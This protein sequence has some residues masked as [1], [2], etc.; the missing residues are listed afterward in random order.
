MAK[1]VFKSTSI[2]RNRKVVD[3][4]NYW[5]TL[6]GFAPKMSKAG[7]SINFNPIMELTSLEDG[8]PAPTKD[9]GKAIPIF[10]NLNS[11]GEWVINDFCH[12][13]GIPMEEDGQ[14]GISIPGIWV[15]EAEQDISK[16]EYKGPL[17]GRKALVHLVKDTYQ[18]TEQNKI[19][20]YVCA[21][22]G[23]AQK[24]PKIKHSTDLN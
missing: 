20:Y 7:D 24:F 2:E 19:K 12:G 17:I 18:G 4:G 8:S 11:K 15:P 3:E 9:D 21:V 6:T 23:C 16:C 13:F 22:P 1:L 10:S 14:G 5:V